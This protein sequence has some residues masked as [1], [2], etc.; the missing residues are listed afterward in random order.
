M[1]SEPVATPSIPF[2]AAAGSMVTYR[3]R[4]TAAATRVVPNV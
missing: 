4:A 3:I 1:V 2:A